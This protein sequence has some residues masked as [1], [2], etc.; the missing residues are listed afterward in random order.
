MKKTELFTALQSTDTN[1]D[2]VKKKKTQNTKNSQPGI[3][4][5]VE[6]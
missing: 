5:T 3:Y 4:S 1:R 2:I 6:N